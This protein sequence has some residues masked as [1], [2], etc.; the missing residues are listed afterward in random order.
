MRVEQELMKEI[1]DLPEEA[2]ERVLRLI[3]FIKRES[4]VSP[5]KKAGLNKYNALTDVDKIA[6]ETGIPDLA[7]HHGHYLYGVPKK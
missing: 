1:K 3:H 4:M 2:Q 6:I 5:R 7:T